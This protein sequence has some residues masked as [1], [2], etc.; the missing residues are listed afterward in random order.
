MA[1]P[2]PGGDALGREDRRAS[3]WARCSPRSERPT[4]GRGAP[5]GTDYRGAGGPSL[6][7]DATPAA[8]SPASTSAISQTDQGVPPL[9]RRR[10]PGRSRTRRSCRATSTRSCAAGA[11]TGAA[12]SRSRP[13]TRARRAGPAVESFVSEPPAEIL[14]R[15]RPFPPTPTTPR[16]SRTTWSAWVRRR[17]APDR[18]GARRRPGS[19]A[20]P[21]GGLPR[22]PGP[23][24]RPDPAA[25]RPRRGARLVVV[26]RSPATRT[27]RPSP[28]WPVTVGRASGIEIVMSSP[29]FGDYRVGG[30]PF[31]AVADA[32]AVRTESVAWGLDQTLRTALDALRAG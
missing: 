24:G 4:G 10:R 32:D 16:R 25:R 29:A 15:L 19:A 8:T 20:L 9:H 7:T 22:L 14:R 2:P 28:P 26:T 27:L 13:G 3:G 1:K 18:G 30:P 6:D 5:P 31:L 21:L 12:S 23:V 11:A 17:G